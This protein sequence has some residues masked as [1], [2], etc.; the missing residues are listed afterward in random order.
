MRPVN[1]GTAPNTYT[2]YR[3]ATDDLI[4]QIGDYCCYC[5][6]QIETHLAVE[7]VLPKSINSALINSWSNFLLACVNCNSC[8]GKKRVNLN[9]YFWPDI[10]NTENIFVYKEGGI[11]EIN[12][13]LSPKNKKIAERTMKLVGLHKYPGST[14]RGGTPSTRDKR[15]KNRQELWGIAKEQK[16]K[17]NIADS[18]QLREA[19]VS[20]AL[21]RG[22]FSIWMTVF[23]DDKDIKQR[24][25]NAFIGTAEDCFDTD[26]NPIPRPGGK[27]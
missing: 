1:K 2:H 11:I 6:R 26:T 8:K 3:D 17:L 23:S 14:E 24:F 27:I 20:N 19:I 13:S 9:S 12:N 15:W 4:S 5:E 22:G 7:H 21:G 10:D 18:I 16:N 25:I